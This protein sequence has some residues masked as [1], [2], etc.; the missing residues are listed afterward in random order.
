MEK[1]VIVAIVLSLLVLLAWQQL[2]VAP[3]QQQLQEE[4]ARQ[5]ELAGEQTP[6]TPEDQPAPAVQPQLPDQSVVPASD[7]IQRQPL[8]N[9]KEI[10]VDTPFIHAVLSTQGGRITSWQLL[11]HHDVNGE[12]V[13]LISDDAHQ[14]GQ[15]PLEVFT[16]ETA[17]DQE[18][19]LGLY[20]SS[21][22][23]LTLEA[24]DA[25][26]TL[27]LSYETRSGTL[28]TKELTF[29]PD[30]Y[31]VDMALTFDDAAYADEALSIMWG[32]GLGEDLEETTR[33]EIGVVTKTSAEEKPLRDAANKL[34]GMITHRNIQWTALNRKYFTA[35]FF[36]GTPT[37]TLAVTKV[38]IPPANDDQDVEPIRQIML[39]L[40]QPLTAGTCDV[41][42][43][44]GPKERTKLAQAY[45]GFERLIDYGFF[46]FIAQ[47]LARFM[48]YLYS[49]LNNYGLVI[50][51]LT[52][53]IKILFYPLTHKSFSS[54]KKMQDLQPKMNALREKYKKDTQKINQEMMKLYKQE[55]V[56]PMGG[57]LPMVLQIPV[58]FALYQTLS[59]SIE[60]RGAAFLWISDLSAPETLFFRPLVLM[61]GV[62]MFLQQ[63][64]TPTAADNKQ[65]QIFKFMPILF[66]A[67]FWN[68]PSGLVL[69]WF[70]NNILTIGQQYLIKR[71]SHKPSK[72][73]N[74]QDEEAPST[75]SK[76]RKRRKK[77]N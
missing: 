61:M 72:S 35:A 59:Q 53:L 76:A 39:G 27:T 48:S 33:F 9:A 43:Y 42:F 58:F 70:M 54:M 1:N 11:Q 36:A 28:F 15:Y 4:R 62:S 38:S 19:N 68:F 49:Y 32:P 64:M 22:S 31:R 14:R 2:F 7:E 71:S 75:S 29:Y 63:S 20:R 34:D 5:A 69:Y 8:A 6:Q 41:A 40:T 26:A 77:G 55:G 18:L 74:E 46:G 60:L 51:C 30:S 23:A 66:T 16:G 10:V 67:M 57:C 50:I 56:N 44:A 21:T 12:P 52:I 24:G 17:L 13:D 47:P 3:Q 37:N 65:A 45:D 73:S 25:P